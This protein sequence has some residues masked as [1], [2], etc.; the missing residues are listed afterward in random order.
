MEQACGVWLTEA[1]VHV[2]TNNGVPGEETER[3]W[4]NST[5]T[6]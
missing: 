4:N 5:I 3:L 6:T 2:I 1:V